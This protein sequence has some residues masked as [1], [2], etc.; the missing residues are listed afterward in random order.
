LLVEDAVLQDCGVALALLGG[1]QLFALHS[2]LGWTL[3]AALSG[4]FYY[5][6]FVVVDEL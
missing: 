5:V 2:E 1:L 3:D 6:F 4:H